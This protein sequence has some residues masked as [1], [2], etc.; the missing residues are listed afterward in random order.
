MRCAIVTRADF[1]ATGVRLY[2]QYISVHF[3][4]GAAS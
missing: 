4:R 3:A 1:T 2:D